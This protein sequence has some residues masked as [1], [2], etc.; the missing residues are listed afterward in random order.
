MN[1]TKTQKPTDVLRREHKFIKEIIRVLELSARQMEETGK[2]DP[3]V[4]RECISLI[5]NFTHK[6]HRRKE[7]GVLFRAVEGKGEMT[8]LTSDVIPFLREHE[9]GAEY[10]RNLALALEES[11]KKGMADKKSKKMLLKN[12]YGYAALLS[13]HMLQEEKVLYPRIEGVLSKQE[14]E[15]ILKSFKQLEEEM[16]AVG[17]KERFDNIIKDSKKRLNAG[18]S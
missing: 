5:K 13:S 17:D 11:V 16:A 10:V 12:I 4:L 9:E 15:N 14:Q 18:G 6:Y 2:T 7:E 1:N 8:W 3:E